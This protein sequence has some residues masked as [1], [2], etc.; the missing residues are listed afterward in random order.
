MFDIAT[1]DQFYEMVVEDFDE[2]MAETHS[3]RRAFHC[4]I[5]AY[6]LRE[7]VW[8]GWLAQDVPIQKALGIHDK[9]SFNEW[10]NRS[11]VWFKIIRSLVNGA[12]HF[13]QDSNGAYSE[14]MLVIAAPLA[15]DQ[16]TAG[17]D[18]VTWAGPIRYVQGSLPVGLQGKGYLLIDLGEGASEHRWLPA[19]YLLEVVVRF[20]RDFFRRFHPRLDLPIS[21]YHVD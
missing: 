2:Y 19:A 21:K 14:T 9:Q 8:G 4:A 11:C 13:A 3:A 20:W 1:P 18:D 6:H 16:P 12:K 5:S 17:S 15:F 10:V 7:W